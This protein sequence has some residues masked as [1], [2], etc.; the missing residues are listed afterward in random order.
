MKQQESSVSLLFRSRLQVL[1]EERGV[2]QR[3]LAMATGVS[4]Q[5]INNYMRG[6]TKLPGA[7]ELLALSRYFQVPMEH[8]LTDDTKAARTAGQ[9]TK[10]VVAPP[11]IPAS[12]IRVVA[13]R[14]HRQIEERRAEAERL[15]RLGGNT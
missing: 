8:F 3:Q 15:E 6:V 10:G 1:L 4:Q 7:E 14:M 5:T 12:E 2:S 13:K 9:Q 11:S